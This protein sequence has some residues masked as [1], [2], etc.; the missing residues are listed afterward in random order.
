MAILSLANRGQSISI[1]NGPSS[2]EE[3]WPM[4]IHGCRTSP[5][6]IRAWSMKPARPVCRSTTTAC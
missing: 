6:G 4:L 2:R 1:W 5:T 3:P